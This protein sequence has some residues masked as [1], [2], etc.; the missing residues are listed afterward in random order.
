MRSC[1]AGGNGVHHVGRGH[2]QHLR[3]VVVH[4]EVVILEGGV[5]LRVQHF[6]QRRCR[7]AAEVRGHLVHFV[8][9]EDGVL[10]AGPL[11]V[12]NDLPGQRADVGA[13]MAANL[14]LVAH[15]AQGE[16]HK[17][18]AGGFGDR[19]SQRSFAHARRPGK[20][21]NRAF[22]IFHQ[23]AHGEKFQNAL[24]DFFQAVVVRVQHLF[25]VIDGARLLG[26]LLPRH[27]QQPVNVV[28]A[29]GGFGRHGRHGF[30]L[31][32]FLNGLVEHFLGH[33]GGFNL[34]AQLVELAL[35][36]AAQLLLNGLDLF[37]QVVLFLRALHLPLDA[38]LD[39][40]VEVELF[41]LHVQHV[42][43]ARQANRG[44][45]ERQQILL[46]LDAQLQIGGDGVAQLGRLIHAHAGDDGLVVER[47]L[48][49]DVLLE[50]RGDALHQSARRPGSSRSCDLPTR[51][52]ATKKPSRS[53]TSMDLARSTPSTRTLML[54]SGI[55]TLCT[56]L[57]MEPT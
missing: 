22:G 16:P 47:L 15:A 57:Q 20:T 18:A 39:V 11:H 1:S 31:F 44:I 5:L 46:L 13:A 8:E 32:Q 4:V 50:E 21:E 33:S 53:L 3:E 2:K 38:R 43:D 35:L 36:A 10:G 30:Q 25:G 37:V 51:T 9:Q 14:G 7:I 6:E 17:L 28:A 41:N 55:L 24:L 40:A 29:D 12:L 34:F 52:V 56:M 45:E 42:G 48:Q 26:A 49:L 23:L 19:H 54:P 27:G